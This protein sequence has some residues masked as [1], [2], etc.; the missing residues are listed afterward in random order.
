[1]YIYVCMYIY[2]YIYIYIYMYI[3]KVK[4]KRQFFYSFRKIINM[5]KQRTAPKISLEYP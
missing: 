5:S 1:M 3:C 2:I 4:E